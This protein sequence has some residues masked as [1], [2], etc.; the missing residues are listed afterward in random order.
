MSEK[1][2]KENFLATLSSMTPQ[3]MADFIS[4]NGKGPKVIQLVSWAHLES[5]E[6]NTAI[7]Q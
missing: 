2:N 3:E 6:N 7:T 1:I 5:S 4:K